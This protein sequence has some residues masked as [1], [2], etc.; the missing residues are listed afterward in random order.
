MLFR[1]GDLA[2]T[3]RCMSKS[4]DTH[5]I[6]VRRKGHLKPHWEPII[7]I[8][9]PHLNPVHLLKKYV[10]MTASCVPAGS[11]LLRSLIKPYRPLSA[12]AIGSATRAV[13]KDTISF[14][15]LLSLVK[16]LST[17]VDKLESSSSSTP[18]AAKEAEMDQVA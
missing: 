13:L 5:Y 8:G 14:E 11:L 12:N 1:S 17:K 9:L 18:A 2:N 7:N 10:A 3:F 4:G 16:E 6:M 15:Q